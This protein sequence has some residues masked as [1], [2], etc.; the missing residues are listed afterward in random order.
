MKA[1]TANRIRQLRRAAGLT[2]TQL[3]DWLG[4]TPKHVSHLEIGFRPAGPQT[5]RLLDILAERVKSGEW[6]ATR[7][8]KQKRRAKR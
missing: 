8:T 2:Q 7:K 1:W 6:Q 3:A 5:V 4:V